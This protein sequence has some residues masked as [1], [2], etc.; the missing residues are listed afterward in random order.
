ME[1][2]L[3]VPVRQRGHLPRLATCAQDGRPPLVEEAV[4]VAYLHWVFEN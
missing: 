1:V 2:P 3:L 4:Y